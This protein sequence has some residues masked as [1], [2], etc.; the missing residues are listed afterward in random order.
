M[1]EYGLSVHSLY[2]QLSDEE[3]DEIVADVQTLFPTCGNRQILGHLLSRG[4][5]VQVT[6]TNCHAYL[7]PRLLHCRTCTRKI[8][9]YT[10][11]TYTIYIII[12]LVTLFIMQC[13][14]TFTLAEGLHFSA[15]SLLFSILYFVYHNIY[16]FILYS[17]FCVS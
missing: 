7:L 13:R 17:K 2:T 8:I 10:T 15:F 1:S 6:N 5:R 9:V 11:R 12:I 14:H 3:L 16:C 4:I